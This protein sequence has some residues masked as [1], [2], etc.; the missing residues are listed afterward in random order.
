MS[1]RIN[2]PFK[3]SAAWRTL[4][5]RVP[6][7]PGGTTHVEN[8]KYFLEIKLPPLH[9]FLIVLCMEQARP[10]PPVCVLY[11]LPLDVVDRAGKGYRR[12]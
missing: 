9:F 10:P 5:N 6:G 3:F 4:Q 12:E 2:A 7:E 11:Y 1:E 8:S